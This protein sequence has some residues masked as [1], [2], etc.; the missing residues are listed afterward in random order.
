MIT[1]ILIITMGKK[2][3]WPGGYCVSQ[4]K[5]G[6]VRYT[7]YRHVHAVEG[8]TFNIDSCWWQDPEGSCRSSIE[9]VIR[10][11]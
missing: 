9:Y 5:G 11:T 3:A 6:T 2:R 7:H 8:V 1:M 10:P 4:A